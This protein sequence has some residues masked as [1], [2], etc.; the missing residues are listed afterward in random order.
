[1][2]WDMGYLNAGYQ[3]QHGSIGLSYEP[4]ILARGVPAI[5]DPSLTLAGALPNVKGVPTPLAAGDI[6]ETAGDDT[7]SPL[8]LPDLID[9][10]T[11][12]PLLA[13][14]PDPRIS[15]FKARSS[16]AGSG[17]AGGVRASLSSSA[18]E[19]EVV[20]RAWKRFQ[21]GCEV[22]SGLATSFGAVDGRE[23]SAISISAPATPAAAGVAAAVGTAVT[24]SC[25]VEPALAPPWDLVFDVDAVGGNDRH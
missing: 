14:P 18:R 11:P 19:S 23:G 3:C 13:C 6:P 1:M 21:S 2:H 17:L 24:S 7:L 8:T 10:P 16:A 22:P 15:W 9:V 4:M 12:L 20:R 25:P 5:D